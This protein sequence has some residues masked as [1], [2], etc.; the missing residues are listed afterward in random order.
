MGRSG[1]KCCKRKRISKDS[2]DRYSL[3]KAVLVNKILVTLGIEQM[4]ASDR[5]TRSHAF[6]LEANSDMKKVATTALSDKAPKTEPH[7]VV[8][9]K[10]LVLNTKQV[11]TIERETRSNSRDL[12][13]KREAVHEESDNH[14]LNRHNLRH[15]TS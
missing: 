15:G 1:Q 3:S 7:I 11:M 5:Q 8:S 6:D 13:E 9:A 10:A 12:E 14:C 4:P 2:E